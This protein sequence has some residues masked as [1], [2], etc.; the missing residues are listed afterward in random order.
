MVIEKILNNNAVI[1]LGEEQAEI[2]VMGRGVAFGKRPGDLIDQSRIEKVFTLK[3]NDLTN[4]LKQLIAEI[5]IEYITVSEEIINYAKLQLGKNLNDN[6]YISL[7]DH[8][9][10]AVERFKKG[11]TIKNG[12]L[13]EIKNLY[14]EE[15]QIGLEALKKI[16]QAF[17]VRLP[18]DEAAFIALHIVNAELN[19]DIG[20]IMAMTE[21]VQEVL[22]IVQYHY[23]VDFDQE[24]LNYYRFI[25]HLKFFAQ[26]LVN[27]EFY[28]DDEQDD[29]FQIVKT[30]YAEAY[31]CALKI[32]EF[33]YKKYQYIITKEEMMYLTI[34]IERVVRVH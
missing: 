10:Y 6:I 20:N 17:G 14:K 29:L 9:H 34:H 11:M 19:E 32:K 12:L 2:I 4:K 1:S 24:S 31:D 15:F 25:T 30:R 8:I 5:P 3:N 18:E 27:K 23:R 33:I 22:K 13:W 16:E 7:T 28:H 21:I 26:R